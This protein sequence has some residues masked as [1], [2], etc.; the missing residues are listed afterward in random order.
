MYHFVG[1][2][3]NRSEKRKEERVCKIKERKRKGEGK[4][5]QF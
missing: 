1:K 3:T 5:M 4:R 2:H